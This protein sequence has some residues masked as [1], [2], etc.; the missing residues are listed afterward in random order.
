MLN[1]KQNI[2]CKKR[3]ATIVLLK[4]NNLCLCLNREYIKSVLQKNIL[5]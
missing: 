5:K 2:E 1:T 3:N 4:T